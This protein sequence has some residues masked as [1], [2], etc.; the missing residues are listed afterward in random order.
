MIAIVHEI[1]K[2]NALKSDGLT[3]KNPWVVYEQHKAE[4]RSQQLSEKEYQDAIKRLAEE[5]GV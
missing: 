3:E 2:V 1:S 4:L 5:L